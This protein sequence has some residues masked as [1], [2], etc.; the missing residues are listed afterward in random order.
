TTAS[1][2]RTTTRPAGQG[3]LDIP[4][5]LV[6]LRDQGRDPSAILELWTPPEEKLSA[7]IAKEAEWAATSVECLRRLIPAK[8]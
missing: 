2:T 5:L 7:T 3:Q 4:W 6:A 8:A 1:R